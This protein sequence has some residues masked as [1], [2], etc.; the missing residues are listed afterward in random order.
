MQQPQQRLLKRNPTSSEMSYSKPEGESLDA[1][2]AHCISDM[3]NARTSFHMLHLKVKGSGAYAAHVALKD[4]YDAL[5]DILDS[6]VEGYQG[7][8]ERLLECEYMAPRPLYTIEDALVYLRELHQRV[9]M[10]QDKVPYSEIVNNMDLLK[11]QINSLKYK[12]LF[13]K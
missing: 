7:V 10:L 3:M 2:M 1:K 5:P 4:F 12:L 6:I 8:T 9:T 11:D 13:L